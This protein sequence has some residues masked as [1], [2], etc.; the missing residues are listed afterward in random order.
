MLTCCFTGHR[1][2][3]RE[4]YPETYTSLLDT[5][6]DIYSKGYTNFIV[7]AADG[8]DY[9][10]V[11]ALNFLKQLGYKITVEAAVPYSQMITKHTAAYAAYTA[12]KVTYVCEKPSAGS[13]LTRDRYMVDNSSLVIAVYDG[14][15]SGGTLYTMNYAKKIGNEL[16]VIRY[17]KKSD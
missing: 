12:D 3:S 5:I 6:K 8:L 4:L 15:K 10:A 14:R 11:Y 9:E 7:G 13:Y 16:I 2:F 1:T 17:D